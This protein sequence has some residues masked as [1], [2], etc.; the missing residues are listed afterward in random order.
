MSDILATSPDLKKI[1]EKSV[2]RIGENHALAR[3]NNGVTMK[4]TEIEEDR[5][6][7][8][9]ET[10]VIEEALKAVANE[11]A[12]KMVLE[13][14]IDSMVKDVI[15][16]KK[17]NHITK[18]NVNES[19]TEAIKKLVNKKLKDKIVEAEKKHPGLN[20]YEK[21]VKKTKAETKEYQKDTKKKFED[22][23]DFNGDT[24]PSFPNQ[25][26]SKTSNE[27]AD[28]QH[29]YYRNDSEDQEFIDDFAYPGLQDFDIHNTNI[30]RLSKYLEGSQETGNA[31]VDK[32]G[33][34][35]GNVG[36]KSDLGEK[37]AK[38]AKRRKEKIEANKASMTNLRGYTPDVQK[39][40]QVKEGVSEDM[41]NMKK[42]WNYRKNTQ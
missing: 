32:D 22:Y 8:R 23:S 6:E 41:D 29:Q 13:N 30:E 31:Q 39:V 35:L 42:L 2:K 28:G 33:E 11:M 15:G 20:A 36:Y 14:T 9:K 34:L 10:E 26:G 24:D 16:E 18:T 7:F 17:D 5:K 25:E 40:K 37:L 21:A 1:I 12:E 19:T 27:G 4:A 3:D 38:S